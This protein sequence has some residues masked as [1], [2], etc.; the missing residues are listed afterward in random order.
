[1]GARLYFNLLAYYYEFRKDLLPDP[2]ASYVLSSP[3]EKILYTTK[4]ERR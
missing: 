2:I 4:G 1:M 3:R